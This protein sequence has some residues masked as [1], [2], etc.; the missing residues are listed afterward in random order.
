[1]A[2][3]LSAHAYF[4]IDRILA[5]RFPQSSLPR[6]QI[7]DVRNEIVVRLVKRLHTAAGDP[8][9]PPIA[10]FPGYVAMVAFHAFDDFVRRSFPLRTKLKDR[11]RYAATH[12]TR[13]GTWEV[14]RVVICGLAEWR[15]RPAAAWSGPTVDLTGN[16]SV[17]L[18]QLFT[19]LRGPLALDDVVSI[20]AQAYGDVARDGAHPLDDRIATIGS[21][22]AAEVESAGYLRDLWMEIRELPLRQRVALL[23]HA[24]SDDGEAVVRLLPQARV[25]T[26]RAVA[27]ALEMSAQELAKLWRHLPLDDR[28]IAQRLGATRPQV[29]SLRRSARERLVRRMRSRDEEILSTSLRSAP[30]GRTPHSRGCRDRAD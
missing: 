6:D 16:L 3:L 1:M 30:P 13:L 23:L 2:D 24:R 4:R 27:E 28:T 9:A 20:F 29:I 22:R 26:S 15:G 12:E 5:S 8:A 7:E 10:S 19:K 18:I 21:Q 11:I 25:A 14:A 17:A